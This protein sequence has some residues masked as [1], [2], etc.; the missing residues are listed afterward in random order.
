[1][2]GSI[3]QHM[4][5]WVHSESVC[6]IQFWSSRLGKVFACVSPATLGRARSPN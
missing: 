4:A 2:D 1:M 3:V 5:P 6:F